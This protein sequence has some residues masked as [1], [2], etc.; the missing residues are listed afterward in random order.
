MKSLDKKTIQR[1]SLLLLLLL[2]GTANP[3][4]AQSSATG[5][6]TLSITT[7]WGDTLLPAG[8][9]TCSIRTVGSILD[10]SSVQLTGHPVSVIVR[11]KTGSGPEAAVVAMAFHEA[12]PNGLVLS[13]EENGAIVRSLSLNELGLVVNFIPPKTNA[14]QHGRLPAVAAFKR[15]N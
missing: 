7:R 4:S 13:S 15:S 11:P 3:A 9:Y 10:L 12:S 2:A 14:V 8:D 1:V 5:K 6:F